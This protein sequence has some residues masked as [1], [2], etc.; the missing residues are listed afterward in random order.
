LKNEN[1]AENVE[2]EDLEVV[3]VKARKLF[4]KRYSHPCGGD[5]IEHRDAIE[6][7]PKDLMEHDRPKDEK[8][9]FEVCTNPMQVFSYYEGGGGEDVKYVP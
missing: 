8:E 1:A 4:G 5:G 2:G 7:F 6:S 9:Q 3:E